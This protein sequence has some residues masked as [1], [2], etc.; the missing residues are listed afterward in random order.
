[1]WRPMKPVLAQHKVQASRRP[2][3][4]S[5]E[6]VISLILP[7]QTEK[8]WKEVETRK[9][10][11]NTGLCRCFVDLKLK[12]TNQCAI[13]EFGQ[14]FSHLHTSSYFS[15]QLPR[16]ATQKIGKGKETYMARSEMNDSFWAL[17]T[18]TF[19]QRFHAAQITKEEDSVYL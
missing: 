10:L 5:R 17:L 15:V 2:P 11:G 9:T 6:H 19:R 8:K 4:A 18:R 13:D 1:M 16:E 3:T 7:N 12:S 14:F